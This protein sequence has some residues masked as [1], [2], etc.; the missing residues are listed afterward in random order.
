MLF[1]TFR[2]QILLGHSTFEIQQ[3]NEAAKKIQVPEVFSRRVAR[4]WNNVRRNLFEEDTRHVRQRIEDVE[5]GS[6]VW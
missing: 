1:F 6:R 3:T 2:S 4:H 5:A